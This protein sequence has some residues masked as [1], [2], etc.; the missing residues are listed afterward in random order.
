MKLPNPDTRYPIL[1]NKDVTY[2]KPT[3]HSKN[4]LVGDFTYFSDND[5][6][7]HVTHHFDIYGDRL[8]IGKFCQIAKGVKFVMNGANHQMRSLSTY[9]F[10]LFEGWREEMPSIDQF[11][12]K[13]DTVIGNDVWI[14]EGATILPGV[15]IGDGCI[16]GAN[17]T[18]GRDVPPYCLAVG[19][20]AQVIK[21]R[22]DEETV[23][24]LERLQWWN[25]SLED[26]RMLI[27]LLTDNE[28]EA[29]KAG[30]RLYLEKRQG[31][32][33]EV[34]P[35]NPLWQQMFDEEAARIRMVLGKELVDIHHIGSTAV[36]GL[37]AKLVIDIMPV[38]KDLR[39]V[40]ALNPLF[41]QLGYE[42]MGEFGIP[43]R[44]YFRKGGEHRTHQI[45][46]FQEDNRQDIVRHLAVR[47]YLRAHPEEADRYAALKQE[48]A[49]R[50]PADIESYCDGK[51]AFVRQLQEKA[52]AW[53]GSR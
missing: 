23:L 13:G 16:I 18:V 52:L 28:V 14:G 5:F 4:I 1:G 29:A 20:P 19:N 35:Y 15:H 30:I 24:L 37:A 7:S 33:V 50:F 36:P 12:F 8:I 49:A 3:L 27:P 22:F 25:R 48:L 6:E 34:V 31:M 11:P 46:I 47:D 51:D 45:H 17:A 9:P 41:G 53:Y 40:D 10:H 38:V 43:G 2:V 39:R 44:R 21:Q 26:I 42:C 32:K